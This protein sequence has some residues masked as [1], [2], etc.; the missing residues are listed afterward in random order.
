MIR[1]GRPRPN[2]KWHLDEVVIR[3][4]GKTQWLWRAVDAEGTVLDILVQ[5][6][7]DTAV[8]KRFLRKLIRRWGR[9][10][11]VVTD[12]LGSYA[13]A[14]GELVPGLEYRPHKGLNNRAE[15]SH[16]HTR[17][18]EKL[19]GRFKS[20]RHAQRLLS[21]HDQVAALFGLCVR[22]ERCTDTRLCGSSIRE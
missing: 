3:I 20:P 19:L 14:I 13:K 1:R 7:R 16:R 22:G 5:S 17:R 11:V 18:R 15:A 12:K 4:G 10:R 21:A 2:D 9:P 6:R 8:A